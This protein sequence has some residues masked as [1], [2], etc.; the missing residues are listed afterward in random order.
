M[1]KLDRDD[2]VADGLTLLADR[3]RR[4]AAT[5]NRAAGVMYQ[6]GRDG[7][8]LVQASEE[9][10]HKA[11]RAKEMADSIRSYPTTATGAA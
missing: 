6:H 7:T 5:L 1:K 9:L 2:M 8:P 10:R 11:N 4:D 3:C